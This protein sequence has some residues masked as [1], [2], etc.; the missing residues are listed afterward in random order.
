MALQNSG[1]ISLSQIQTQYG[2]SNPIPASE[3]YRGGNRVQS[4]KNV[5][6]TVNET[7]VYSGTNYWQKRQEFYDYNVAQ[8]QIVWDGTVI[9]SYESNGRNADGVNN[10]YAYGGKTY[11]KNFNNGNFG[12][13]RR[14]YN[15]TNSVSLNNSV[16]NSGTIKFSN[17]Y[18]GSN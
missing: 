18:G 8:T 11:Y 7:R 17:F 9:K 16:P 10:S 15:V 14:S 13:L 1:A 4:S 2:G 6:N 3:Y 12:G 5:T